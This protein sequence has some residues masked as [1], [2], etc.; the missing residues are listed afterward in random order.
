MAISSNQNYRASIACITASAGPDPSL[1]ETCAKAGYKVT[2]SST[3]SGADIALI[4]SRGAR[5]VTR[6]AA[7]IAEAV[8]RNS[9]D[10]ALIFLVD[11]SLHTSEYATLRR[12][13]DVLP[14]EQD[15]EHVIRRIRETIRLRN[16]AEET[17]ERLK[18]LSAINRIV[19]FPV[20]ATDPSP[21]RVLI[22]GPPGPAAMDTIN[23]VGQHAEYCACVLTAGQAM[24]ALEHQP[25]DIAVFLPTSGDGAIPALTRALRRHPK[26]SRTAILQIAEN[27]DGLAAGARRGGGAD[28]LIQPHISA[29]LG[30]RLSLIARRTRLL[31]AMRGFLRACAGDGVRDRSS[32]VFTPTFL[33]QH[34]ARLVGRAEQTGR[35]LSVILVRLADQ[36]NGHRE[37]GRRALYQGARL[38]GRITRAEDMTA[39]IAPG[40]FGILC[41]ATTTAD[42]DRIALRVEGVLS[43]T[44]FH[45]DTKGAPRA[46]EIN[47][48]VAGHEHG[49][50]ISETIAAALRQLP[51]TERSK[52][53]QR[54]S[55]Q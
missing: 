16:V 7:Q 37:N 9:P 22:V 46:L 4:D 41:P 2:P 35:S 6:R 15:F 50:G 12:F 33:G 3:A 14:V 48:A 34:G 44:A 13:G 45:R 40:I 42:A 21:P 54:Q 20:I 18:S 30:S 32:G 11:P 39:R 36:T 31:G 8:R 51:E 43:N 29:V 25:F 28:F 49:A 52:P 10:C 27:P 38:L 1:T 55:P 47:V 26:L 23:A 17:G 24:R 19:D 5:V 53:P